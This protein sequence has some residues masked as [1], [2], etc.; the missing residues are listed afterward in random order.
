M[1]VIC[2]RSAAGASRPRTGR[3]GTRDQVAAGRAD[4]MMVSVPDWLPDNRLRYGRA[5]RRGST[6]VAVR[7][8]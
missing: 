2:S 6:P 4:G 5:S 3:R 7:R 1:V 8:R